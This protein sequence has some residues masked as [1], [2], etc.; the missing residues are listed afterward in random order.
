M[1]VQ[2]TIGIPLNSLNRI[3]WMMSLVAGPY[4]FGTNDDPEKGSHLRF[5]ES[6]TIDLF[7]AGHISMIGEWVALP[8]LRVAG[9][10]RLGD[11]DDGLAA[12]QEILYPVANR[13]ITRC[14]AVLRLS[15]ESKGIDKDV[16]PATGLDLAVYDRPED[17]PGCSA[18]PAF[19]V[20]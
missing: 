17:V 7:R 2:R 18:A 3:K 9:G 19:C 11:R 1:I 20:T 5:L 12:W 13:L 16:R 4:R 15:G 14:N 6:V 10:Q 8:L